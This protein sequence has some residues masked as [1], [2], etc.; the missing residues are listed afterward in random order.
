M[1]LN[2]CS[3]RPLIDNN[4]FSVSDI[5]G[6]HMDKQRSTDRRMKGFFEMA[7]MPFPC[8]GLMLCCVNLPKCFS[9]NLLVVLS[10]VSLYSKYVLG[11]A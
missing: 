6:G 10:L 4:T 2:N 1:A 11:M 3:Q 7:A 8:N 9:I 5:T